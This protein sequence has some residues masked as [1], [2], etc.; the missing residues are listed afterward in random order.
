MWTVEQIED[1]GFKLISNHKLWC[2]FKGHGF[3]V[4]I[5]LDTNQVTGNHFNF[6]SLPNKFKGHFKAELNNKEELLTLL[7][8]II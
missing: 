5:N 1:C 6:H 4:S 8:Y 3:E 2:R 7:S